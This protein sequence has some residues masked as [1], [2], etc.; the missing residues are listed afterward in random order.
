M[1]VTSCISRT[2]SILVRWVH[3]T[4]FSLQA[5]VQCVGGSRVSP[6]ERRSRGAAAAAAAPATFSDRDKTVF[7]THLEWITA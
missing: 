6:N 3:N 5:A 2:A 7:V 1:M 4:I